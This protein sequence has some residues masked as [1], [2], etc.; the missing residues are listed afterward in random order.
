MSQIIGQIGDAG[1]LE[2]EFTRGGPTGGADEL[3]GWLPAGADPEV[4]HLDGL[5]SVRA[6]SSPAALIMENSPETL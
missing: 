1:N 2:A 6:L 5:G 3:L 4:Y